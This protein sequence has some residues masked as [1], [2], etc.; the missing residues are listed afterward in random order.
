[1]N[2]RLALLA[3]V[4]AGT[5]IAGANLAWQHVQHQEL[6]PDARTGS[7][8][9]RTLRLRHLGSGVLGR[10]A[11]GTGADSG[12]AAGEE[13]DGVLSEPEAARPRD[14]DAGDPRRLT[15]HVIISSGEDGA[16][17]VL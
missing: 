4:C 9:L 10:L 15:Y 14:Y 11:G 2:A 17:A 3:C 13:A 5:F 8:D 7:H 6:L 1:M 12:E 16:F